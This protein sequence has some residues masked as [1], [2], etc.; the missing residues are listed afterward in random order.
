MVGFAVQL[1]NELEAA[2]SARPAPDAKCG[3]A[4]QDIEG[5]QGD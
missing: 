3:V 1:D 4:S 2:L 5:V